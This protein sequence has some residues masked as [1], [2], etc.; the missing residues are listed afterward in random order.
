MR[1]ESLGSAFDRF[2]DQVKGS[3]D[4]ASSVHLVRDYYTEVAHVT[5]HHAQTVTSAIDVPFVRTTY[6]ENWIARYLLKGYARVDPILRE[7]IARSLPFDWIEVELKP[8][9]VPLFGDFSAH[10]MSVD[11]YSIPVT[12]KIRRRALLS[13]NA[14][15]DAAQW[16]AFVEKHRHEWVTLAHVIHRKAV[17]ELYGEQDPIPQVSPRE[18]EILQWVSRGKEAKEIAFK[19]GISEH[20][21]RTYMRSVRYKL[22]CS[23]MSQAV[24]KGAM[25]HLV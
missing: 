8:E 3:K 2:C 6:P 21:V 11:G 1:Q 18:V 25:L 15:K 23:N 10:G 24:A 22:D 14:C 7:G 12:D 20:T 4:V 5:Y 19:L 16:P 13:L 17:V 9:S